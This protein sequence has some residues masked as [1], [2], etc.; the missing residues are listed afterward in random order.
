MLERDSKRFQVEI[1]NTCFVA[2][3]RERDEAT[4]T[5]AGTSKSYERARV[6]VLAMASVRH[7][8]VVASLSFC[9]S[10]V[11][12]TSA[13]LCALLLRNSSRLVFYFND[14]TIFARFFKSSSFQFH[15][16]SPS[17]Y[18][19]RHLPR[20]TQSNWASAFNSLICCGMGITQILEHWIIRVDHRNNWRPYTMSTYIHFEP[21]ILYSL[22][23]RQYCSWV[24]VSIIIL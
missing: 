23:H 3:K 12:S 1:L 9:D 4:Q 21:Y 19:S 7:A 6:S 13:A 17:N 2:R 16:H 24:W 14:W 18:V 10:L 11:F 15:S 5:M 8:R 22:D 20:N